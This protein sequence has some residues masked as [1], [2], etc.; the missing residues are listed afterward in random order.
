M[1]HWK[2]LIPVACISH[3]HPA[4][5]CR[6]RRATQRRCV[7][8]TVSAGNVQTCIPPLPNIFGQ[9][10]KGFKSFVKAS[11]KPPSD[12]EAEVAPAASDTA[13]A[14][15]AAPVKQQ[16]AAKPAKQQ[17]AAAAAPP[18]VAA[19]KAADSGSGDGSGSEEG[20]GDGPETR[21]QMLQRH[22]RVRGEGTPC[23]PPMQLHGWHPPP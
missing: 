17:A 15:P 19:P 22:K 9:G 8:L 5:R 6:P 4:G 13:P 1:C 7:L 12:N 14:A 21:G 18:K 16:V 3:S 23:T 2:L 10:R 11:A 20:P